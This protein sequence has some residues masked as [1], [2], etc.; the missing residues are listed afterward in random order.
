MDAKESSFGQ[1]PKAG[2]VDGHDAVCPANT[3]LHGGTCFATTPFA[4][5]DFIF[6]A[7]NCADSGGYLPSVSELLS[8]R[9]EAGVDL[10][11]GASAEWSDSPSQEATVNYSYTVNDNGTLNRVAFASARPSRCAFPLV[12]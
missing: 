12:R 9:D 11:S 3:F 2:Q 10:G 8:I 5:S 6:A 7:Q 1:V 4:G